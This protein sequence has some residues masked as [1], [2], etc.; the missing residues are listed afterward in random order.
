MTDDSRSRP[1]GDPLA[2]AARRIVQLQKAHYGKGPTRARTY[3]NDDLVV[4]LLRDGLTRLEQTLVDENKEDAVLDQRR[5]F[6]EVM[7]TRFT[8]VIEE[9]FG[10]TV[11]AMMS[12]NHVDPNLSA[13]IFVLEPPTN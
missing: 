6:Q 10:R 13:E 11:I 4:V 7:R 5:A 12:A 1:G 8:A 2:N 9:E 3:M